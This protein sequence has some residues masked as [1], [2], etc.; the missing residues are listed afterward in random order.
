[1]SHLHELRGCSTLRLGKISPFDNCLLITQRYSLAVP[2]G[3]PHTPQTHFFLENQSPF[4]YD[5][6][7]DNR[8]HCYVALLP[9]RR[10]RID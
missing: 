2:L 9:D 6:F 8:D 3:R 5:D 7:F 4:H 10:D 1:M